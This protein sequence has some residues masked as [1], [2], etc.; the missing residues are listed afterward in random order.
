MSG[1]LRFSSR[2]FLL[3]LMLCAC[4]VILLQ[5]YNLSSNSSF[6]FDL[7]CMGAGLMICFLLFIP[8]VIIKRRTNLD[9]LAVAS[10]KT[11]KLRLPIAA[12][13]SMYFVFAAEYFLLPYTDMFHKKYYDGVTPCVISLLLLAICV[14]AA[15]KGVNVISR[16]G[17]FLFAFALLAN[18][19]MFGGNLESLDFSLYSFEFKGEVSDFFQNT[20]YF[21]TPGFIAV[22]FAC[23]SGSIRDFKVKQPAAALVFTGVKFSLIMFFIWFATGD[24]ALR[25]D[26]RTFVLARAARIMSFGGIES[27]YL[28]LVTMSV[29]MIISLMLCAVTK[30]VKRGSDPKSVIIFAAIIFVSHMCGTYNNSV[31]E[32]FT[33]VPL[34]VGFT[35]LAAA[36]IP[37]LY[38]VMGRKSNAKRTL[39]SINML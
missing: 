13:Y 14:Y 30:S 36:V 6:T 34:F 18:I 5:N 26:Y 37:S 4:S 9:F 1:E 7:L 16:F 10:V 19:L 2:R 38:L 3:T 31:K 39:H 17:I 11:P 32:I 23:H 24:Y 8:S 25:Q 20:L 29:F 12:F 22:L 21:I 15:L 35:A 28:A 33:S 27:F